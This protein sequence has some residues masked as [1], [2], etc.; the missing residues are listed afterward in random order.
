VS[1]FAIRLARLEERHIA[2]AR[3]AK[4]HR[5]SQR[6][7]WNVFNVYAEKRWGDLNGEA[8]RLKTVLDNSVALEKFNDYVTSQ[9]DK[10][11]K[12]EET[13][14]DRFNAYIAAQTLKQEEYQRTQ[15]A[16]F[17]AYAD[18]MAKWRSSINVRIAGWIGGGVV[19]IAMLQF[20]LKYG[21]PG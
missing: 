10:D 19:F 15:A 18:E 1:K 14:R 20:W 17:K 9:R 4:Q 21:G 6:R 11:D 2:E 8:G 3:L 7:Q 12:R 13:Q 16:A 5:K